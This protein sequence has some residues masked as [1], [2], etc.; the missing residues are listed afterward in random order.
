MQTRKMKT[1]E[2]PLASPH[3]GLQLYLVLY[4]LL[5]WLVVGLH[6][7]ADERGLRP[8]IDYGLCLYLRERLDLR[9]IHGHEPP[10]PVLRRRN[11]RLGLRRCLDHR[12]RLGLLWHEKV[13][14][15]SWVRISILLGV[16]TK[17]SFRL[18]PDCVT[19]NP[20]L[21]HLRGYI[22]LLSFLSGGLE[23]GLELLLQLG[24]DLLLQRGLLARSLVL[25]AILLVRGRRFPILAGTLRLGRGGGG[26]WNGGVRHVRLN[27]LATT[28]STGGFSLRL[29]GF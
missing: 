6:A 8:R 26:F 3:L 12:L 27:C 19:P 5:R 13:R 14:S 9:G 7:R 1:L 21:Y 25:V 24:L 15:S 22:R 4:L 23:L 11:H 18:P 2:L 20:H 17:I 28:T 29:L 10:A 16:T